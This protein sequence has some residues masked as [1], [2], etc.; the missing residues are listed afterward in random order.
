MV[1]EKYQEE[2]ACDKRRL[3]RIIIM[4]MMMMI[5]I[6]IIA[7][8][9]IIICCNNFSG[10]CCARFGQTLSRKTAVPVCV[11]YAFKSSLNT[12][13][14]FMSNS[15]STEAYRLNASGQDA[16]VTYMRSLCNIM[17]AQPVRRLRQIY[18]YLTLLEMCA[19]YQCT[20][21]SCHYV[22]LIFRLRLPVSI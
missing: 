9:I 12:D 4:M 5:I 19:E 17:D 16:F 18:G 10:K 7:I 21:S 14:I 20:C 13:T 1:Q 8:I 15:L 22:R 3:Y 11:I 6:I 2:K